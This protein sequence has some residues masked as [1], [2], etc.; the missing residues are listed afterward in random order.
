MEI[1][2]ATTKAISQTTQQEETE[3]G[4]RTMDFITSWLPCKINNIRITV[5]NKFDVTKVKAK[6][7]G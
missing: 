4:H 5:K 2:Q 6:T 1:S 7:Y 3:A